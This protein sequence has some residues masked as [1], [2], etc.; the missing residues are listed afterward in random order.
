MRKKSFY[1]GMLLLLFT[2]VAARAA[3]IVDPTSL[4]CAGQFK[5]SMEVSYQA[6][7]KFADTTADA[8]RSLSDGSGLV[9]QY[10]VTDLALKRDQYY[11]LALNYGAMDRLDLFVKAGVVRGGEKTSGSDS[12]NYYDLREAFAW[13]VGGKLRL[14]E[15]ANGMSLTLAGQYLRFDARK[16]APSWEIMQE[17]DFKMD[18]WRAD[19]DLVGAWRLGCLT[20]Y[21]GA[22]YS[23]SEAKIYGDVTSVRSG[24]TQ[25]TYSEYTARNATNWGAVAGLAWDI[26]SAF[27]LNLQGDFLDDLTTSLS[28]AYSF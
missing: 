1:L 20:P 15:A 5:L 11:F 9:Y 23:Y 6:G 14:L 17:R 13:A 24:L 8:S 26:N 7:I 21:L 25:V 27:R 16:Q 28:L 10:A 4:A 2:G 18:H 22:K 19:L 3:D 12:G